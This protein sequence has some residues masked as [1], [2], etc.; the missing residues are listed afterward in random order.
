M[1][2]AELFEILKTTT[3]VALYGTILWLI[4]LTQAIFREIEKRKAQ[5]PYRK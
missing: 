5:N 3:A 4:A 2:N 1:N